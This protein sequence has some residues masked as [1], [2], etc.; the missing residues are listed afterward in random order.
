MTT[1][2]EIRLANQELLSAAARLAGETVEVPAGVVLRSFSRAVRMARLSGCPASQL[3]VEAE[4]L[5]R[6]LLA[7]RA[8]VPQQR[9]A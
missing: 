1:T 6:Q 2:D 5:T 4:R 9:G 7:L 3:C 8:G